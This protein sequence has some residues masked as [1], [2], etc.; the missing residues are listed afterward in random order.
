ME[1]L[2]ISLQCVVFVVPRGIVDRES[3]LRENKQMTRKSTGFY[4]LVIVSLLKREN[5]L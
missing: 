2:V 5:D 1:W 4:V 3:M